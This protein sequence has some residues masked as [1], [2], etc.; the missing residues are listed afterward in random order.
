MPQS[1]L[2]MKWFGI[3]LAVMACG[4]SAFAQDADNG[5][6]DTN[7]TDR[8]Y[9]D[10]TNSIAQ[11]LKTSATVRKMSLQDC[12]QV[13]LEHNFTIKIAR[14]N[15]ALARYNLWGSYGVY[16]PTFSASYDHT[17][18]LSPGGID[19]QGRF[20]SGV[21]S[22]SDNLSGG[23]A[24]MLPWGLNYNLGVSA[25]DQKG[26]QPANFATTNLSGFL[27]NVFLDTSSNP[28]VLLSPT[29]ATRSGR[30]PFETTS[31]SAGALSLSQPLLRNFWIDADR[32]T[33]FVNK[34]ELEKSEADFRDTMMSIVTQVEVAYI[35]L[36]QAD[37]TIRVQETALELADRTAAENKKR[38][39]VGAMAPLDEQQAEAQA[40]S[41]R[42]DLLKAE[43][44]AGQQQRVLKTLLSDNYTNDWFN[45]F[46]QP[47]EKLVAIPQQFNLQESWRKGLAQGGSPDRLRQLRITLEE[48]DARIRLQK[49]QL[50]P[51]LDLVG[52]YGYSGTGREF[53]DALGQIQDRTSPSW[54][55]GA[56]MTVPLSQT[57]ARNNLKAAKAS[58]DQQ[59]LTIKMQEQ[60]TLI[61]I[62][63]DIGNARGDYESVEAT[64]TARLYAEA[65]LDAEQKKYENGKSTLFDILGL[66]A[67][68]TTARSDEINAL[69]AYNLVLSTLSFDEG[70]TFERL[71]LDL[72]MQ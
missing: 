2:A 17:Y 41:T 63:N 9:A 48:N 45:V 60:N 62:E 38:V 59:A 37:E 71:R 14:Y 11:D 25:S 64:H 31:A 15:P 53:S 55:I 47:T 19:Q 72:K 58:R 12:I 8:A 13:A 43:I 61:A 10:M 52:S 30:T 39:Q 18:N 50:F 23:L 49:N 22:E 66:Q 16:D 65:A 5:T 36:I 4:L 54:S 69:A 51:E 3:L 57:V 42:A 27:T 26:T 68:L 24:G 56:Q 20:F 35:T 40:A 44:A 1:A 29:F 6:L 67:K 32:F 7:I 33:I 46:I 21:E 70:S 34:K 28:V